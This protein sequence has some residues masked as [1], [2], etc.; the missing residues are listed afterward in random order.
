MGKRRLLAV[1]LIASFVLCSCGKDDPVQEQNITITDEEE[2]GRYEAVE[3]EMPDPLRPEN[4]QGS[5]YAGDDFS[6]VVSDLQGR[7]AIYYDTFSIEGEEY[8]ATL[9]RW[10]LME[11][12][13]WKQEELCENSLSEFLNQKYE[14]IG[15]KWF[16]LNQFCRGDDGSLYGIFTYCVKEMAKGGEGEESVDTEMETQR[17]SV[18]QI[19]EENDQIFEIPLA[20]FV[21]TQEVRFRLEEDTASGIDFTDYHIFEDGNILLIYTESGGEYGKLVDGETGQTLQELGNIVNGRKRF[22]FGENEL[23]FFSGEN[24]QFRVLSIPDLTEDNV[25]GSQLSEEVTSKE[26]QYYTNPDT[27]ELFL[28]NETG[29]YSAVSYLDSDEVSCLTDHTDLS[30]LSSVAMD[31]EHILNFLVGE[32]TDFYICLTGPWESQEIG[33]KASQYRLIYYKKA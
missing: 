19:D 13:D 31:E 32:D 17:Y 33:L 18:L 7:P 12:N 10:T 4:A 3:I 21:H 5:D 30:Q 9:T 27:W 29:V 22:A 15:W 14:Q 25:F 24:N 1:C 26:W 16:K 8:F 20:D 6:G 11:T 2:D 23:I 28:C